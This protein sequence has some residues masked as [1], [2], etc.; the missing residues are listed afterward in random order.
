MRALRYNDLAADR[1]VVAA[2]QAME[3]ILRAAA[4]G[5]PD[6]V[7]RICPAGR[8]TLHAAG[9]AESPVLYSS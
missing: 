3:A 1:Q 7:V 4:G 8:M 6:A 9:A 2:V 5:S